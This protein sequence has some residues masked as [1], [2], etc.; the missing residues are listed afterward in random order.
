MWRDW[1]ASIHLHVYGMQLES[2]WHW[3]ASKEA[4]GPALALAL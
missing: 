4:L 2:L 1:G 3:T